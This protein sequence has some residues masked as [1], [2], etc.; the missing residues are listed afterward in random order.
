M[1]CALRDL[2]QRQRAF[3]RMV[4]RARIDVRILLCDLEWDGP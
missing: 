1:V 3:W 4:E 2:R